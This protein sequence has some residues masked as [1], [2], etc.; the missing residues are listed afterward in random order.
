MMAL[1]AAGHWA[2]RQYHWAKAAGVPSEELE[3]LHLL[4]DSIFEAVLAS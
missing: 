2:V 3:R 1:N 4:G